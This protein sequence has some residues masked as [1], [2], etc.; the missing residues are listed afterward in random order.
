MQVEIQ[1]ERGQPVPGYSLADMELLFGDELD[2]VVKWK[3][4][5]DLNSMIGK[6]VR[7]RFVLRDADLFALRTGSG[8]EGVNLGPSSSTP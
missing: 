3:A 5:T 7:V 6:P 8:G 2:A 4:G 1:D